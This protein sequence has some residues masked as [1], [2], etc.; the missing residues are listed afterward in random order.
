M[1]Y[2]F[3]N[4]LFFVVN[5]N[6]TWSNELKLYKSHFN[7][8]I[9]EGIVFHKKSLMTGTPI[10][11]EI[12]SAPNVLIFKT[13][14]RRYIFVWPPFWFIW[15]W[16]IRLSLSYTYNIMVIIKIQ[17]LPTLLMFFSFSW[18]ICM[19]ITTIIVL[20]ANQENQALTLVWFC[21]CILLWLQTLCHVRAWANA[22]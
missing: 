9:L 4:R 10:P 13:K 1:T 20:H 18:Y 8:F 5:T 14:L 15:D 7:T 21:A 2:N 16:F 12:V 11:Y 22:F 17:F 6:P 19:H 3:F